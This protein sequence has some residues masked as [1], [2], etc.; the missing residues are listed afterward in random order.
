MG[1]SWGRACRGV[2]A[3]LMC[4][5]A[6]VTLLGSSIASAQSESA[7]ISRGL[8]WLQSQL[9]PDGRLAG[10]PTSLANPEQ[11]AAE[12]LLT[13]ARFDATSPA[14][15]QRIAAQDEAATEVL[16]RSAI[17]LRYAG[18]TPTT[19]I[20]RLRARQNADGGFGDAEGAPSNP[21][22]TSWTLLAFHVA[23]FG[24]Y[25]ALKMALDYLVG[26]MRIDGGF[27]TPDSRSSVFTT[28]YALQA[29]AA[30]RD[31]YAASPYIGRAVGWLQQSRGDSGVYGQTLYDALATLALATST[32]DSTQYADLVAAL[33]A[34]QAEDGSWQQDPFLTSLALRALGGKALPP[35]STVQGAIRGQLVDS[36]SR[37]PLGAASI[38]VGTV[39]VV[40]DSGGSFQIAGLNPGVQALSMAKT[41]YVPRQVQLGVSAGRTTDAGILELEVSQDAAALRG[42]VTDGVSGLP[43]VGAAVHVSS[44]IRQFAVT[45]G[46]GGAFELVG[47]PSGEAGVTSDKPGYHLVSTSL[48]LSGGRS[49]QYSPA[50]F[51]ESA[52][53][54][55]G[56][57]LQGR[58]IAEDTSLPVSGATIVLGASSVV[59]GGDGR[60]DAGGLQA[61]ELPIRVD[62]SGYLGTTLHVLLSAGAN[63]VGDLRLRP[64]A[65]QGRVKGQ[66]IDAM[67]RAPLSAASIRVGSLNLASDQQGR[68]EAGVAVGS[69]SLVVD[70][71]GYS[72]AQRQVTVAAG[73]IADVGTIALAVQSDRALLR[74]IVTDAADGR[75]LPA[76]SITASIGGINLSAMTAANGAFELSGIPAGDGSLVAQ[77]QGFRSAVAAAHF[78][79]G[80][81]YYFSP[82]LS[83]DDQP[84]Q[85]KARL[86]G[87][88]V[89]TDNGLPIGGALVSIG[90]RTTTS[91]GD[92]TF[93]LDEV[94]A[95]PGSIEV[96]ASGYEA[97]QFPVVLAAGDN[98]LGDLHLQF[99]ATTL[100]L[101]GDVVDADTGAGVPGAVLRVQGSDF[102]AVS[103]AR[104]AWR[105][106]GLPEKHLNLVVEASGYYGQSVAVNAPR[107]GT[108]VANIAL[109]R[110]ADKGIRLAA[111]SDLPSYGPHSDVKLSVVATSERATD[112]PLLFAAT[113]YDSE[114]RLVDV[115]PFKK[116]VLGQPPAEA[117]H[118][119][120]ANGSVDL[121]VK[122]YNLA[123]PA[124]DYSIV[125]SAAELSGEVVAE[126][127]VGLSIEAETVLGGGLKLDPPITQAGTGEAV[128]IEAAVGNRGNLP[129]PGGTATLSIILDNLDSRIPRTASVDTSEL[130]VGSPLSQPRGAVSD[131]A[132]NLYTVNQSRE[133]IQVSPNGTATTLATL[134]TGVAPA[135]LTRMPDGRLRILAADGKIYTV[136]EAGLAD[137]NLSSGLSSAQ[138]ITV[139]ADGSLLVA[140]TVNPAGEVV[141]RIAPDGQRS[142]LLRRGFARPS[143]VVRAAD[144]KLYVA[145][146]GGA[147]LS[148]VD[149][150]GRIEPFNSAVGRATGI[151][152]G[153]AG[154]LLVTDS[155]SNRVVHVAPSG[156]SGNYASGISSPQAIVAAPGGGYLVVAAGTSS[157]EK[158]SG[159]S[160]TR[161]SQSFG[162]QPAA[163]AYDATGQLYVAGGDGGLHRL[164]GAGKIETLLASGKL[165]KVT[166]LVVGSGGAVYAVNG[167]TQ[168][169]RY[170]GG[171]DATVHQSGLLD[172]MGLA[173]DDAGRLL[174][175]EAEGNRISRI[176]T[177]SPRETLA[178]S[179]ISTP[180]AVAA[181]AD[182]TRY[183]LNNSSLARIPVSGRASLLIASLGGSAGDIAVKPDGG[184]LLLR[185]KTQLMQ[186]T[187]A[188]AM[189]LR[190]IVPASRRITVAPD[191]SVFLLDDTATKVHR[192]RTNNVLETF[193]TSAIAIRDIDADG[194]GGLVAG[195]QDGQLY[196]YGANG[197]PA[198]AGNIGDAAALAAGANGSVYVLGS[199]GSFRRVDANGQTSMLA[200]GI[201]D[202]LAFARL[203]DGRFDILEASSALLKQYDA[204]GVLRRTVAGFGAPSDIEWADGAIAFADSSF[205]RVY[206]MSP[207]DGV[208]QLHAGIRAERLRFDNGSL[209][210]SVNAAGRIVRLAV[211]GSVA[212]HYSN[213]AYTGM[214]DF[215]VRD[216]AI[217]IADPAQNR[218]VLLDSSH[219]LAASYV[220]L[221]APSGIAVDALGQVH[222]ASAIG[223]VRY[224]PDGRQSTLLPL[225]AAKA[226]AIAGDGALWVSSGKTILRH[227]GENFVPVLQAPDAVSSLYF[228]GGQLYITDAVALRRVVQGE[229]QYFAGGVRDTRVMRVRDGALYLAGG[230]EDGEVLRYDS[231]GLSLVVDGLLMLQGGLSSGA[232]G[233]YVADAHNVYRIDLDTEALI[234]QRFDQLVS[235]PGIR[236]L[237]STGKGQLLVVSSL[238]SAIYRMVAG[239]VT[240]PPAPGTEVHRLQISLAALTPGGLPQTVN[241]GSWMPLFAGDYSLRLAPSDGAAT[242]ELVGQLHVGPHLSGRITADREQVPPGDASA[243]LAVAVAGV[244]FTTLSQPDP[245]NLR[246]FTGLAGITPRSV[247]TDPAG[248]LYVADFTTVVRVSP[249]GTREEMFRTPNNNLMTM[250]GSLPV[251]RLGHFYVATNDGKVRRGGGEFATLPGG[252]AA[253]ALTIDSHDNLLAITSAGKLYRIAPDGA[254]APR[255][256]VGQGASYL[257]TDGKDNL[258]LFRS[259]NNVVKVTPAGASS[260]VPMGDSRFEGGE[261]AKIAADCADNLYLIPYIWEE[262][263]QDGEEHSLVMIPGGSGA[264]IKLFDGFGVDPE[265]PD[266]DFL[267][268]DRYGKA[269]LIWNDRWGTGTYRMPIHCGDIG[270]DLHVVTAPGQVLSGASLPPTSVTTLEDGGQ[271]HVWTLEG[272]EE[273]Q[274]AL[275]FDATLPAM[276]LG[277]E[278]DAVREAYLLFR[279]SFT[280]GNI[281]LPLK[282]PR[283]RAG[284][285]VNLTLVT[286]RSS[287][288]AQTDV[289]VDLRLANVNP[290][291]VQGRLL[292][293]LLDSRGAVVRSVMDEQ[294][295]IEP[296]T[297]LSLNP[298]LNTGSYAPDG[299]RLKAAFTDGSGHLQAEASASFAIAASGTDAGGSGAVKVLP[300]TDKLRYGEYED[301]QL[302][303]LLSSTASNH[304]FENLSL[305]ITV[306]DPAGSTVF[307]ENRPIRQ[308][309]PGASTEQRSRYSLPGGLTGTFG[310]QAA[311][312]DAAGALIASGST[313]FEVGA[314]DAANL[315]GSVTASRDVVPLSESQT[316]RDTLVNGAAR[317][318]SEVPV[319]QSVVELASGRVVTT[320]TRNHDLAASAQETLTRIFSTEGYSLGQHACVLEAQVGG[321]WKSLGYDVFSIDPP[322]IDISASIEIGKK[323]RL[324]VL[325][326]AP[327]PPCNDD[328]RDGCAAGEG[329]PAGGSGQHNGGSA[330]PDVGG[331]RVFLEQ[332]LSREGWSYTIVDDP[333]AFAWELRSGDYSVYALFSEKTKLDE[334]LQKELREAVYRGEGLLEAGAHDQRHQKFDDALGIK[335][336]GKAS[337]VVGVE[338]QAVEPGPAGYSDLRLRDK[339]L[340][341]QLS[342]ARSLGRYI[343]DKGNDPS[344]LTTLGY[345]RGKSLYFGYDLLAEAALA[346]EASLHAR[347]LLQGLSHVQP[348]Y[349]NSPAGR[350]LPLKITLKN[351]GQATSGQLL[352]PMPNGARIV[353][354]DTASLRNDALAWNYQ[355]SVDEEET[356]IAWVRLP[357]AAAAV[358]F[359]AQVLIGSNPPQ[360]HTT[361]TLTL[362]PQATAGLAAARQLAGGAQEFKQVKLW[363]DKADTALQRGDADTALDHLT[364][365]ADE[366]LK[367]SH[368]K[369]GELRLMIDQ[370]LLDAGRQYWSG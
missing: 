361:A 50:L 257:S 127:L 242:G 232:D 113:V 322:P 319:R 190:R 101:L 10:E 148:R 77:K 31:A 59:S 248:N 174:V 288:P 317:P 92:G 188:G 276:K 55:E 1:N 11:T 191:G 366:L 104:G 28:A 320:A 329:S 108:Q 80:G 146:F 64:S 6:A 89:A 96:L 241:L 84:V 16:A 323:G 328:D 4:L 316:C 194:A 309:P 86:S 93:G 245:A 289:L 99:A 350:V 73:A 85:D 353:D 244:D 265:M 141:V 183:I 54:P 258:Y 43:L 90:G 106:E 346:G 367:V 313:S 270:T 185:D 234:D 131:A 299:Y 152:A 162:N 24:D 337:G 290:V 12:A 46:S 287:Y 267:H 134:G 151:V 29:L 45:T 201:N 118:T 122:W 228:D 53:I 75:P 14:L 20:A 114:R 240:P 8:A 179:L 3:G 199:D 351:S 261:G 187:P 164:N 13:L 189:S 7:E 348:A 275:Q 74:G 169:L 176:A 70:K 294:L 204:S 63:R 62:A 345:G 66:V 120:P 314:D 48:M 358:S 278:R 135:D 102:R 5:V 266:M 352:L 321:R 182:G 247:G 30:Y 239:V 332:L 98:R 356:F 233:L 196:R 155:A 117:A 150:G 209:Y 296:G 221:S 327:K 215:A 259:D 218:V 83:R 303:A 78:Q 170:Q 335:Y 312:L 136:T 195:L 68:F 153:P 67:T 223:V 217:A 250:Q 325:L 91:S 138:A 284:G 154:S 79:A 216:G 330:E 27:A 184:L 210:G 368:P 36:A 256:F 246:Q 110:A 310:L 222:V 167:D 37:M 306:R 227:D 224:S 109:L 133:V 334:R 206:R 331:Q 47:I 304:A 173:V 249:D 205:G 82:S 357:E 111:S 198:V 200:T 126:T 41:G 291:A 236:G 203:A 17:A 193:T 364:K 293:E 286:D 42:F 197:V 39:G 298:P 156:L 175:T 181:T 58:V 355:L 231:S 145:N 219:G 297:T 35:A 132:G 149:A 32:T 157:V 129:Y 34:A 100:T 308:L 271:E 26:A 274:Q 56:A 342:S 121:G 252:A 44:G 72:T 207:D 333:D 370:A 142:E 285:Q 326:D 87:R 272:F 213:A 318:L 301:V 311:V 161:F 292:L 71:A 211:D 340:K 116:L 97:A 38:A 163:M 365:A 254:V 137:G 300:S 144:G 212:E 208:A 88:I 264:P 61:G 124:G 369:A 140:G 260:L 238:R 347:Q 22:D 33:K 263:G 81:S 295:S 237:A 65:T 324:L 359:T 230:G 23:G 18:A 9:A 243:R 21:L 262:M 281:K 166:D 220:H 119:V 60:F 165:G 94:D 251:D 40:T 57:T 354:R 95:G 341:A 343:G 180:V 235:G 302:R 103:N 115:V 123:N 107:F 143:G 225:T 128:H 349:A 268:Y 15:M 172:A 305:L 283:L 344:A 147:S 171:A 307:G 69:L 280:G 363:L 273:L 177:G 192:L 362:Q 282:L 186:V 229:L 315:T 168:V 279:N 112:Q 25:N 105:I 360:P 19:A 158:V 253:I 125:I 277:E 159:S 338:V 214:R 339:A 226:L 139:D 130:L 336:Q 160:V 269:L 52:A 76:A 178:Q 51:P 202:G 49:Y 2:L 255:P